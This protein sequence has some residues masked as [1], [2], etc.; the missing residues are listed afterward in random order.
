M[1]YF[2][3]S[4]PTPPTKAEQVKGSRTFGALGPPQKNVHLQRGGRFTDFANEANPLFKR[5]RFD[6]VLRI[7]EHVAIFRRLTYFL[8]LIGHHGI[9]F[10]PP[11]V[12]NKG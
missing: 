5:V 4:H 2:H 12:A 9:R 3:A 10:V 7:V 1:E 6:Q 8:Y 11:A